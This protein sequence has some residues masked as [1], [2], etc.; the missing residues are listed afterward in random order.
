MPDRRLSCDDSCVL[1]STLPHTRL[2]VQLAPGIP[3]ALF[4]SKA[5]RFPQDPGAIAPRQ[6]E[7]VF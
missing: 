4:T 2:R 5:Q 3:C 6:C 7:T 1:V